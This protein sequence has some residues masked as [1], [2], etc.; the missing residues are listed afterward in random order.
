MSPLIYSVSYN[1]AYLA[2]EAAI[3]LV[4]LA[5]PAVRNALVQVKNQALS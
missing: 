3:T 2:A 4:L 1:G 5:V